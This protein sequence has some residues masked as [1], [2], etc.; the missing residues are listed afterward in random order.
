MKR[1]FL[2]YK[3]TIVGVLVSF[4]LYII[5]LLSNADFIEKIVTG[6][7]RFDKY[8]INELLIGGF[9]TSTCFIVDMVLKKT[10]KEH[11]LLLEK[12]KLNVLKST[13]RTMQDIMNNLVIALQ[14]LRTNGEEDKTLDEESIKMID[15]LIKS[16]TERIIA[17]SNLESIN[18]KEIYS[19]VSVIDYNDK[20]KRKTF[21]D[22]K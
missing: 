5:E 22:E 14:Y 18:E 6:L 8:E 1:F 21:V 3:Y 11:K 9:I 13:T 2:N 10:E 16:A 15:E 7:K 17:L 12:Q 20:K 4:I 19:G